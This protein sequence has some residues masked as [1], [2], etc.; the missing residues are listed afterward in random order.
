MSTLTTKFWQT[1]LNDQI[2]ISSIKNAQ[3]WK[4]VYNDNILITSHY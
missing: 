3:Q 1:N 4:N 2:M